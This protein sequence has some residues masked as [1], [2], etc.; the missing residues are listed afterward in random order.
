MLR[1][2][3]LHFSVNC[4]FCKGS[5][6]ARASGALA[7]H[8]GASI[9]QG[10]LSILTLHVSTKCKLLHIFR[11]TYSLAQDRARSQGLA[12][13]TSPCGFSCFTA[14]PLLKVLQQR[15]VLQTPVEE[16]GAKAKQSKAQN[17]AAKHGSHGNVW[18]FRWWKYPSP[19]TRT[20][21]GTSRS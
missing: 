3:P 15:R 16:A 7:L 21:L 19:S 13:T 5:S 12:Y 4:I 14:V 17:A 1:H 20:A 8:V 11:I 9:W 2:W 10:V 6:G 18:K